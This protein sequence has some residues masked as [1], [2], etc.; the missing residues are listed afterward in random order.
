MHSTL[1]P[2]QKVPALTVPLAGGGEFSL[3][4]SAPENFTIVLFYRGSWCLAICILLL[5]TR[6]A[7]V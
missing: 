1:V 7:L 6:I 4:A 2:G 5:G 3:N